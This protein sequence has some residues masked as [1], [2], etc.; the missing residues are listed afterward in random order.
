MDLTPNVLAT[1]LRSQFELIKGERIETERQWLKA[2]RQVRGRYEPEEEARFDKNQSKTF[3]RMTRTKVKAIDARIMDL[4]FPAGT[5]ANWEIEPTPSPT[6]ADATLLQ[7]VLQALGRAPSEQEMET[8]TDALAKRRAK[9]MARTIRDQL[10]EVRYRAIMKAVVHSG[11]MYGTGILKGPLVNRK[12]RNTWVQGPDGQWQ[13][14]KVPVTQPFIEFTP[15][16]EVYPETEATEFA[17]AR[18]VYQRRV[19]AKHALVGL[20]DR[21]DFSGD[22]IRAYVAA[23]R[24]GDY[25]PL[26]WD[27]ELK[28]LGY[29]TS[30]AKIGDK[31]YEVLEYWGVI[32][33]SELPMMG[34]NEIAPE[35]LD[36]A[37]ELWGNVWVLGNVVIKAA[38]QPI[39]GITLPF[40]AY[41]YD[42][43][44]TSIFGHG[45]PYIIRDDQVGLN[46][47]VRAMQDNAGITAGPQVEVNTDLIDTDENA[48]DLRPFKVWLRGG[49]GAEASYDAVKI[50]TLP[51]N[52]AEFLQMASFFATNI[53]EA[54]MPSYM[55]GEASSKGSVG[56]TVGGLSLLM[57]NAQFPL[58]DQLMSIDDDVLRPFINAMYAWN[59]QFNNDPTIKGDYSVVVKGTS[60]LVAREIRAQNLEQFATSTLNEYD[61]PHID[62]NKLNQQRAL[63]QELGDDIV[64]DEESATRTPVAELMALRAANGSNPTNGVSAPV[65]AVPGYGGNAAVYQPAGPDDGG[66]QDDAAISDG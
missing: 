32:D 3:T 17:S 8:I 52:T 25:Q 54:T 33:P 20:G 41:Y 40:Y 59:M 2:L 60:S 10:A 56:R 13:I 44:E 62:R 58:K 61:A 64:L 36:G 45:V 65:P 57:T 15:V 46:A 39:S 66:S 21:V 26:W 14:A 31:R 6:L 50:K 18:Y 23:H 5:E 12:E 30:G 43:D 53:H 27:S 4:L 19:M 55:H 7:M 38:L 35:L 49:I 47:A 51:S 48:R 28:T 9:A 1:R 16:W 34:M 42:K 63:V 22:V 11:N 24:E 29:N 37:T